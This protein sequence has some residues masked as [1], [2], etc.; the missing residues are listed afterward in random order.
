MDLEEK[1][2]AVLPPAVFD[3]YRAG[4]GEGISRD[5]ASAAW[6]RWRFRPRLFQD[7]SRVS[8]ETTL[9]GTRL[10]APVIVG[11]TALHTLAHAEGEVATARGW[12]RPGRCWCIRRGPGGTSSRSGGGSRPMCCG[13]GR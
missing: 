3:Y 6:L 7:V 1:A 11:P 4:A 10:A 5:E 13:T 12:R 2:K 9:L 8:T